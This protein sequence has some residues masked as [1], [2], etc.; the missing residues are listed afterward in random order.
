MTTHPTTSDRLHPGFGQERPASLA[1]GPVEFP[2]QR[3]EPFLAALLQTSRLARVCEAR[4]LFGVDGAGTAI[5]VLDTGLRT[6]H[7][8]FAGRVAAQYNFTGAND[9]DPSDAADRHGHGTNVAG[10]ICADGIHRGVAPGARIVPLKVLGDDG[11]G[12]FESVAAALQWVIDNHQTH[13]ITALCLAFADGSNHLSD[14]PFAGD[15]IDRRI[16]QLAGLGIATVAAAGDDYYTHGSAQGMGYPAILR[17][18]ISVGTVY[19][20]DLG[21]QRHASGAEAYE[22][23]ADRIAPF[24]QR[25]HEKVGRKCATDIF[26]PGAPMVS[27]GIL[28][29]RASSIQNGTSQA[30]PVAAGVVLLLQSLCLRST[31]SLPAPGDVRRW[32]TRGATA[33]VDADD[34]HDNVLHTGLAFSRLD[35]V[36]TLDACA[37]ELAADAFQRGVSDLHLAALEQ[38][39]ARSTTITE[40][41]EDLQ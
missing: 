16:A 28:N 36:A 14:A 35:A 9:G 20:G 25:L 2:V 4:T 38:A 10:I 8:D 18:T 7:G 31:G 19:D 3:E 39:A 26:A 34:E 12:S 11:A 15:A 30:T 24:S 1:V 37:R 13:G 27:S 40:A 23:R 33:I 22:T 5:G 6:S 17:G 32:L 41:E 29:D 21:S